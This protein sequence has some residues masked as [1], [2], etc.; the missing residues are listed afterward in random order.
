MSNM[1]SSGLAV[2]LADL[3]HVAHDVV[4]A[5]GAA[6]VFTAL[7]FDLVVGIE[8]H[9]PNDNPAIV[10]LAGRHRNPKLARRTFFE[11][12]SKRLFLLKCCFADGLVDST[13]T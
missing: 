2:P 12:H 7:D 6:A 3:A 5:K 13:V 4:I 1:T 9:E 10:D 11:L 8:Q